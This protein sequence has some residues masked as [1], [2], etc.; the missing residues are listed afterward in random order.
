MM[1]DETGCAAVMIGRGL[2]G[3]PWLIKECKNYHDF[4]GDRGKLL[5]ITHPDSP[6]NLIKCPFCQ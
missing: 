3:N 4:G 5:N 2:L 6:D 1:L